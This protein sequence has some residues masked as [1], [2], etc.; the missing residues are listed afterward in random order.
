MVEAVFKAVARALG[1]AV[2]LDERAGDSVPSTK[3]LL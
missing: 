1:D 2:S 3:S